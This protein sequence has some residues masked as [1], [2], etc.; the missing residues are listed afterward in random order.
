[1]TQKILVSIDDSAPA[2][3]ALEYAVPQFNDVELTA[4]HVCSVE[5]TDESI[6]QRA[7]KAECEA[8]RNAATELAERLFENARE[9]A[10][11]SGATLSTA[12]EYGT[13]SERICA[14][15]NEHEIDHIV[16]GTHGRSGLSR[17]L[18]GSVAEGVMR[19]SSV[20]VTVVPVESVPRDRGL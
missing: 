16:I 2:T 6:R 4:L 9:L 14:Y 5:K 18:L 8:E 13:L 12:I 7:L 3:A 15:A 19:R 1:M 17:L 11:K 10:E 20:P